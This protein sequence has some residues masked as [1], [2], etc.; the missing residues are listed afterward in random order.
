[1]K[2]NLDSGSYPSASDDSF[3]P[4][5]SEQISTPQTLDL[6]LQQ[7][8]RALKTS[9]ADQLQKLIDSGSSAYP[10]M[11]ALLEKLSKCTLD[12]EEHRK[13]EKQNAKPPGFSIETQQEMELKVEGSI[14][15][16]TG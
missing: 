9:G 7:L 1:M 4:V 8:N 6:A 13:N 16:T 12:W 10:Q 3:A 11:I 15:P 5:A 2:T 14:T